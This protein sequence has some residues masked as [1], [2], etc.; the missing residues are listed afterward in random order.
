MT[1]PVPS[2]IYPPAED[3]RLL[4]RVALQEARAEDMAIEIGCGSGLI[5]R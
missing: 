3:T 4:Q 2:E 5:C 1:N